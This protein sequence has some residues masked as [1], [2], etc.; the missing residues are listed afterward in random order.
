MCGVSSPDILDIQ[1]NN[2][3]IKD[4][5]KNN[6]AWDS[7]AASPCITLLLTLHNQSLTRGKSVW[8]KG[9]LPPW[10]KSF[11]LKHLVWSTVG[12]GGKGFGYCS[13][14]RH[15]CTVC[16]LEVNLW[17]KEMYLLCVCLS[18][19]E[20]VCE[21]YYQTCYF[22]LTEY[23]KEIRPELLSTVPSMWCV[24]AQ[25]WTTSLVC[26]QVNFM[27]KSIDWVGSN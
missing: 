9:S 10:N 1:L 23:Y 25:P 24:R 4:D 26:F 12:W 7:V 15:I 20:I 21:L 8:N 2:R 17:Y 5:M 27:T 22:Q 11:W 3:N 13:A 6:G 18:L 14:L 19:Y 16:R